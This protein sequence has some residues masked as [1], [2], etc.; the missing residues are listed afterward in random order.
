MHA[1][2]LLAAVAGQ[3]LLE[4]DARS[5][6]RNSSTHKDQYPILEAVHDEELLDKCKTLELEPSIHKNCG[7]SFL[8]S[9]LLSL[10]KNQDCGF[11]FNAKDASAI[12]AIDVGLDGDNRSNSN[13]GEEGKK[14]NKDPL[15]NH[16]KFTCS[17]HTDL[18]S[19]GDQI[20]CSSDNRK[21]DSRDDGENLSR[22][23]YLSTIKKKKPFS[24]VP[25]IGDRRIRKILASK[26]RKDSKL[27]AGRS[28][29]SFY[30]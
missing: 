25:H 15:L 30:L 11:E 26:F 17:S 9:E 4:K 18:C 20:K 21:V 8:V 24:S 28:G 23:S 29:E 14:L 2:D 22:C 12:S 7:K 13:Q 10:D 3:L 6:S 16:G 1:F 27:K 19:L 5:S